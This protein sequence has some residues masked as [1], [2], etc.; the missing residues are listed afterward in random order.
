MVPRKLL[1]KILFTLLLLSFTSAFAGETKWDVATLFLGNGEDSVFQNDIDQNILELSG[2]DLGS[3]FNLGIYREVDNESISYFPNYKTN[4]KDFTL[5]DILYRKNLN[6]VSISGTL[7]KSRTPNIL[8]FLKNF[9]KDPNSKKA[10]IIYSHGLGPAGLKNYPTKVLKNI[11]SE[12]NIHLDILWFDSCFMANLEFLNELKAFSNY[13]I[14]SEEAEFTAGMPFQYLSQLT[15]FSDAK[16]AAI[17]MASNFIESY[18]Y[19]KAGSQRSYVKTSSATI[20]VIDNAKVANITGL[21]KAI[22]SKLK[23]LPTLEKEQLIHLLQRQFLM[24]NKS[25]VDLGSLLIE[26]RKLNKD[27]AMDAILTRAIR[28][29]GIES[30]RGLKQTAKIKVHSPAPKS[31]LVYGF[32]DWTIDAAPENFMKVEGQTTG[33]KNHSWPYLVMDYNSKTIYPFF[34]GVYNFNYYFLS[35]DG[36]LLT[37][38]QTVS[39]TDDIVE[40]KNNPLDSPIVYS[41]YTQQLGTRAERYTGINISMPNEIPSLDYYELEFNQLA[42]WLSL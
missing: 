14:A 9:F 28:I 41:A 3:Q 10:L 39:R 31:K 29:L 24:E 35:N 5:S 12:A 34:P 13:T 8:G 42:Q 36:K 33:P 1:G 38:V 37:K 32:N 27:S 20:S 7:T 15:T 19:L 16:S 40:I 22:S 18:S 26:L 4:R 17:D 30:V 21:L 2:I 23:S 6:H 25:M 11:L